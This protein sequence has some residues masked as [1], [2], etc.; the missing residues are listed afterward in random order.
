MFVY[1][2]RQSIYLI[3]CF[4]QHNCASEVTK[5]HDKC[6]MTVNRAYFHAL[7]NFEIQ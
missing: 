3:H 1:K 5:M 7:F 2:N 4:T 6:S